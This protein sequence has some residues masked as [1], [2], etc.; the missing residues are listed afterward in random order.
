MTYVL[1]CD[2]SVWN[3]N[4]STP[5][6]IDFEKMKTAGAEFVFIKSSQANWKDQDIVYNW[7]AA[8]GADIL[9]G[10]YHFMTWD[11]KAIKQAETMWGIIEHD[12]GELP[13]VCD[14]EF[15]NPVPSKAY[16]WLWNFKVRMKELSGKDCI[17]YTGAFFWGQYGTKAEVWTDSDLW[18]ASYTNQTYMEG[19]V[20]T[21]TTWKTWNFWQWTSN[22]DG[23]KYG[24]EGLDIDLNYFNGDLAAL[25][26]RYG[27]GCATQPAPIEPSDAEKLARLWQAHPELH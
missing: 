15:W 26:K 25:K 10:A 17:I 4:N 18:I 13:P 22:G 8:K 12:P 23:P 3:D 19:N 11:I 1:G 5:Q 6:Q 7:D 24:S 21:L 2:V 20:K 14:F 9:R 16:D 27:I